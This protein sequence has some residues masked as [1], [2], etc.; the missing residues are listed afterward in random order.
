MEEEIQVIVER[1]KE[2]RNDNGLSI[3]KFASRIGVNTSTCARWENGYISS[4]K[5]EYI[6][7]I[8]DVFNVSAMW[9]MGANVPKEKESAEHADLRNKI[10][11]ELTFASTEDLKAIQKFIDTFTNIKEGKSND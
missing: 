3:T 2:I 9:L 5:T 1:I 10:S 4:L 8:S 6:K 11:D 7:K